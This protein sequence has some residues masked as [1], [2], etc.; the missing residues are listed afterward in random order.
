MNPKFL[1]L[2][3]NAFVWAPSTTEDSSQKKTEDRED[4]EKRMASV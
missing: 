2:Y 3:G 1:A 4:V